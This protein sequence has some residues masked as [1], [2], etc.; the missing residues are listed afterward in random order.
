MTARGR[1]VPL[2]LDG[3]EVDANHRSLTRRSARPTATATVGAMSAGA[4]TLNFF[5]SNEIFL[6]GS[7][8]STGA[9]K[10]SARLSV[11][12]SARDAPPLRMIA[13]DPIRGGGGLEEVERLLDLEHHVLGHRPQHRPR[14]VVRRAVDRPARA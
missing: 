6:N 11:K 9:P 10:R 14:I 2:A 3:E 4:S 1:F 8:G 5:A 7:N 13:V 12:P